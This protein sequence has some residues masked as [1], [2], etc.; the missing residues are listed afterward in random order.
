MS[1]AKVTEI[2][3]SSNQ[4]FEGAGKLHPGRLSRIDPNYF[5]CPVISRAP[6]R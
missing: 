1:V 2:S 4:S 5:I 6:R 3:A